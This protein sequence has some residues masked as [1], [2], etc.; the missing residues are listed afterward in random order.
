MNDDEQII[1]WISNVIW[2]LLTDRASGKKL[3][4][5]VPT[6]FVVYYSQDQVLGSAESSSGVPSFRVSDLF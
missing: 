4:V 2:W 5:L 3:E 1:E 6:K